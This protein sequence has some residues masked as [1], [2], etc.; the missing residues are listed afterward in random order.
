[1]EHSEPLLSRDG[2]VGGTNPARVSPV[3]LEKKTRNPKIVNHDRGEAHERKL[4]QRE[5]YKNNHGKEGAQ[6][7]GKR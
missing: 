3:S 1:M 2:K 5:S 7:Q 6:E 4:R